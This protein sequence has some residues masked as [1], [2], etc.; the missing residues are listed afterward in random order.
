[1]N[2]LFTYKQG[3]SVIFKWSVSCLRFLVWAVTDGRQIP[4]KTHV[5]HLSLSWMC[6]ATAASG[7]FITDGG[8]LIFENIAQTSV[9]G[10][11]LHGWG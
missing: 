1:M 3:Q 5:E 4:G 10:I 11:G 9:F 8:R 6:A 2:E 7:L